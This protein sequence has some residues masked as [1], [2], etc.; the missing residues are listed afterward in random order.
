M[1][2]TEPALEVR[3]DVIPEESNPVVPAKIEAHHQDRS[4]VVYVRQSSAQQV[5]EHREST[6]LQYNLRRKAIEWGWSSERVLVI[7]EDQGH[8]GSTA[9]GRVGFQRLLAEVSLDHVGLILGIEM[10]RLARSCKDWH[11]LL[12]LCAV[13]GTLLADLDGLYNPRQYNDRLLLGLKGTLSEAELHIIR[14]RMSQGRMNKAKRGELFNHAPIGY[15]R[16]PTGQ[17]AIDPDEQ[18]QAV[19]R[20]IF[21]QFEQFG[22]INAVLRYLVRHQIKLAVRPHSGPNRGRLEWHRPNRQTLRNI[23]HHP[24]YAGAYAWGR[25]AIDPRRKIPG[26][27]GTGRTV[28][29]P[30]ECAVFLKD[31][32][33]A[34]ISW[35]QYQAHR[36]QMANNQV[37][38]QNRGPAR[39]GSALLGGLLVCGHCGCRMMVRY[40]R[41]QNGHST[42]LNRPYYFCARHAIDYGGKL[43]QSLAGSVLDAF[44]SRQIL[45]VLE[46]TTL[47]LSLT[48]AE[49]IERQ[50]KKI[51]QQWQHRLERAQYDTDRAARQYDAVEPENRL[52]ARELER[53]WEQKLLELH[54]LREQYNRSRDEQSVTLSCTNRERIQ[55][56]STDIPQLW[57][58]HQTTPADRKTVVRH[59][60]EQ[61]VVT[62]PRDTQHMDVTIHW[63]GGFT[64]HH[65]LVRP[66]AR[67]DQLDNY[68]RLIGRVLELRAQKQTSAQIAEQ[69]NRE[70]YR[71]PKR[72]E[73]FNAAMVR[74][75]LTR[76][77]RIGKR[78]RAI[79]SYALG[80]NEWWISDLARHLQIPKPTLY[81]WVCRGF[82]NAKRLPGVQGP[83]IIWADSDEQG[84][85]RRLHKCPRSWLNRPQAAELTRPK[86]RP[87]T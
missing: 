57:H 48:A 64:S 76:R 15:V 59:L 85:L 87:E 67:Y 86:P 62:A 10:S 81:N 38:G 75:L 16:L 34:Y 44:V 6:A 72:R 12:E 79:E 65:T 40:P 4:A 30:E 51:D 20:L 55:T 80:D 32:C 35:E 37:R 28:V 47:E 82:V 39:Q 14:Q 17:M 27:P 7:D 11:Q 70:G 36:R 42:D 71:P 2:R 58:S 29:A 41:T 68:G 60:I 23:L 13:F 54:E 5:L 26:R 78:P 18:V 83:W 46:P 50:Q 77:V 56:L 49:D 66:V 53:Q 22:S 61:V 73:T 43:C 63:A 24:I 45:A 69:L 8:S 21:D 31:R 25:R 9:A 74:Q 33:P 19:V 1:I 52:V 84:R 3:P